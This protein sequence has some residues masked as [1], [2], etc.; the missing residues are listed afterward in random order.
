[1]VIIVA[2]FTGP[3]G[4]GKAEEVVTRKIITF[5]AFRTSFI[6]ASVI[7]ASKIYIVYLYIFI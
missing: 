5:G 1:M 4:F 7:I 2:G 6:E 3:S